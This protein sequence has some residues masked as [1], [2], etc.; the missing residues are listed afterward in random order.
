MQI[1]GVKCAAC[2]RGIVFAEGGKFCLK[3]GVVVHDDCERQRT[4][5]QCGRQYETYMHSKPGTE[6]LSLPTG[7]R[8]SKNAVPLLLAA[9]FVLLAVV[10]VGLWI[11][12][13]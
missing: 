6:D 4:C 13:S 5:P 7:L 11:I 8:E 2:K 10:W 12:S 1:A 9:L 3:C